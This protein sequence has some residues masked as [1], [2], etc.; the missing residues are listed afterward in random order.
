MSAV[1]QGA[2]WVYRIVITLFVVAVIVEV[3][4]AGLAIFS[5]MPGDDESVA[6]ETF[7]D[8]FEA[9]AGL[10]WALGGASVLLLIAILIAW[11]GP[12]SIS[13]TIALVVLTYVQSALGGAGEDASVAGAFHAVNALFILGLSSF[14]TLR[15]WRGNLLTSPSGRR[16]PPPPAR[17]AP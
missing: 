6:H 2:A 12:R 10:G 8:K 14:L 7:E 1:R 17:P 5:A 9:H 4:L 3:F 13:A 16:A 15:A 11:T